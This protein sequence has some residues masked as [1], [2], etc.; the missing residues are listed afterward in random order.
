MK[1]SLEFKSISGSIWH[2]GQYG[3]CQEKYNIYTYTHTLTY[4]EKEGEERDVFTQTQIK[5][6]TSLEQGEISIPG[7]QP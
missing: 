1:Q 2:F 4:T 7:M 3:I 5:N 6:C